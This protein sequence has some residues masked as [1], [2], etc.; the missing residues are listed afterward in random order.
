MMI[1]NIL[2]AFLTITEPERCLQQTVRPFF[3]LVA[4]LAENPTLYYIEL[5]LFPTLQHSFAPIGTESSKH[6]IT[7]SLHYETFM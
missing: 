6:F 7:R 1:P 3:F 5:G 2:F 4:K